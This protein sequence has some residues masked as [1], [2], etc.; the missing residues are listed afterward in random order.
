MKVLL[1][2]RYGPLGASSRVRFLQYLPYFESQGIEVRV[3]PLLSDAYVK[4]LYNGCF[5]LHEVLQGYTTRILAMLTA[6]YF[7]VVIIE[8]ELFPF[9]PAIAERILK[10]TRVPYVVDYDDALFHRYD[11]HP[12][13]WV[14]R[15][16]G[17]KIDTVMRHAKCVIA[18]NQYLADR[19][20]KAGAP[21]VEIIPT[22]VD[23]DRYQPRPRSNPNELTVG[24]IGTPK[25]SRYLQPLLPVFA[26]LK[27]KFSVRFVAVGANHE[28]FEGTPVDVWP[29]SEDSEVASVQQFDIGIMPLVDSPWERGKCGYKL[30][31]YMACGLPVVASPVGVNREIVK[32][33]ENG[34]LADS[35]DDWAEA[36]TT[37]LKAN[38]SQIKNFG[39]KG[40]KLVV[41]R[42]SLQAQASRFCAVV[43][44]AK[45]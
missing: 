22:V 36:L 1:L 25:T 31:Q 11:C 38:L 43:K 39:N 28:D 6:R 14:R 45:N 37:I 10:F 15:L 33:G 34:F 17:K 35:V 40:R 20:K 7:D 4:A 41:N 30:I 18:G 32:D 16:L 26:S 8:K 24:W 27:Q 5:C 42:Y 12:N 13:H 2:S 44:E 29:W 19:A 21:K 3:K 23:T 9:M